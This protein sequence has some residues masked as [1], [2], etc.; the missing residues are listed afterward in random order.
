MP[1]CS[2]PPGQPSNSLDGYRH[3]GELKT[4]LQRNISFEERAERIQR[5]LEQNAKDMDA[6]NPR[7]TVHAEMKSYGIDGQYIVLVVGRFGEFSKDFVKLRD[8]ITGSSELLR[9]QRAF[10]L[11]GQQ[12]DVDVQAKYHI[13]L[14]ADGGAWL[15]PAYP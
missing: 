4:L 6:R 5:D 7:S 15:G 3:L 12:G 11:I 14:G 10:Q 1:D 8:Y 13:P 2:V 9:V